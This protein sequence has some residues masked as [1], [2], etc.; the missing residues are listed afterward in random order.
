MIETSLGPVRG[1]DQRCPN[2]ATD[3]RGHTARIYHA[4]QI[5]VAVQRFVQVPQPRHFGNGGSEIV[6]Q[7]VERRGAVESDIY[8]QSGEENEVGP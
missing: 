2:L 4:A 8:T 6:G 7:R 5:L 1:R 3:L